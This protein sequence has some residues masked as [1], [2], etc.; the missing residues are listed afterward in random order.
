MDPSVHRLHFLFCGFGS[1]PKSVKKILGS[2]T[3][4]CNRFFHPKMACAF[5]CLQ[6]SVF[7]RTSTA[8]KEKS[9]AVCRSGDTFF[10]KYLTEQEDG[11]QWLSNESNELFLPLVHPETK[12]KMFVE[13]RYRC[14]FDGALQARNSPEASD[15][16]S[17]SERY[18]RMGEI[19]SALPVP[20]QPGWLIE[21]ESKLYYPM[22]H[23]ETGDVIF[24]EKTEMD[25]STR[26]FAAEATIGCIGS[27]IV[28][29][30]LVF[31]K[32]GTDGW[33]FVVSALGGLIICVAL[34]NSR[35]RKD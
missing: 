23:Q 15:I 33:P 31:S 11:S 35:R 7:Y 30:V 19:I 27:Q 5:R 22:N 6:A 14:T 2:A 4:H 16:S 17:D 24:K 10:G 8:M 12:E 18:V 13:V 9:E 25:A 28:F 20:E 32:W 21:A 26:T 34:V 29:T 1:R 3:L